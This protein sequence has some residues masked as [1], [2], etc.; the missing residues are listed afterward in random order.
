MLAGAPRPAEARTAQ[1][2]IGDR[3]GEGVTLGNLAGLYRD[4][5]RHAE[6]ARA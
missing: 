3:G 4:A 1:R 5:G 6:S 2:E